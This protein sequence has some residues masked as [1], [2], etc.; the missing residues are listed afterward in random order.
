MEGDATPSD[1][2]G[3]SDGGLL[4]GEI[5]GAAVGVAVG[6]VIPVR[7]PLVARMGFST[8]TTATAH[9]TSM[10][11]ENSNDKAPHFKGTLT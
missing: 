11:H 5:V 6:V 3:T 9:T 10:R 2:C 7:V 8:T 1:Q 4:V